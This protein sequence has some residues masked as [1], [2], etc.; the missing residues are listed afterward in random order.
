MTNIRN[1]FVIILFPVKKSNVLDYIS[2][3]TQDDDTSNKEKFRKSGC[4]AI[5][6]YVSEQLQSPFLQSCFDQY[7]CA[8][9]LTH[10][11]KKIHPLRQ[12]M[13]VLSQDL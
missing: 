12:T 11:D 4:L 3:T 6:L 8:L 2:D 7:P 1:L 10:N 9:E 13:K 5:K